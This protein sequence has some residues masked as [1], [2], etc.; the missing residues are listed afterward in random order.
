MAYRAFGTDLQNACF[1]ADLGLHD[2]RDGYDSASVRVIGN[3]FFSFCFLCLEYPHIFGV[4]IFRERER[5]KS[6]CDE[7]FA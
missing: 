2:S 3:P 7:L 4:G 5:E 1:L 6:F